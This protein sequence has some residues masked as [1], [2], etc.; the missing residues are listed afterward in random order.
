MYVL[1]TDLSLDKLC[2]L[3]HL[4][5]S[6]NRFHGSVSEVFESLSG[7][8]SFRIESLLLGSNNLSGH[9]TEHVEKFKRII[10]LDLSCNSISGL[11]LESLGNLSHLTRLLIS[12]NQFKGALPEGIGQLGMLTDFDISYNFLQGIGS[13]HALDA[14]N[15]R[16]LAS[17][18]STSAFMVGLLASRA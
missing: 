3:I 1:G 9:L 7:C 11:I 6:H 16:G 10:H 2:E 8:S 15:A 18:F 12:H 14:N 4:D 5:L 13:A 17:S